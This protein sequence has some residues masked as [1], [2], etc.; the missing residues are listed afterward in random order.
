MSELYALRAK[1]SM[2]HKALDD[3][4]NTGSSMEKVSEIYKCIRETEDL[5]QY[6]EGSKV[7]CNWL[8][9]PIPKT[10]SDYRPGLRCE[11]L[12]PRRHVGRRQ[13]YPTH[14]FLA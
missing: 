6:W 9:I 3:E 4:F 8:H 10:E 5:L 1:L 13:S 12:L 7:V 14:Y 2:L 11:R